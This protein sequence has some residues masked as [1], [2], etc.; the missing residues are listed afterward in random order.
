[1]RGKWMAIVWPAF[2]MACVL[3]ILV[4]A[5]VDPQGLQWLGLPL[6]LPRKGVYTLAFF[7]FWAVTSVSSILTAVLSLSAA[8]INEE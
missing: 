8:E 2:L 1:M 4:F 5:L 3:E 6:E 7:T